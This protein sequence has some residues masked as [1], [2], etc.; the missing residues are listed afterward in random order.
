MKKNKNEL[1]GKIIA[2]ASAAGLLLAVCVLLAAAGKYFKEGKLPFPG[3]KKEEKGV[4]LREFCADGELDA[5]FD[6]IENNTP[7]ELDCVIYGEGPYDMVFDD[8]DFILR[9][10]R[11]LQTVRIGGVSNE[12]PDRTNDAG[13]TGYIFRMEDGTS[14]SFS[15]IL[16]SFRWKNGEYHVVES[17][18][19]LK[20]IS[21]ELQKAGN[22]QIVYAYSEDTGFYTEYL[23]TYREDWKDEKDHW[24][25]LFIYTEEDTDN[26][27]VE[28]SRYNG[29]ETDP[30]KYL[31]EEYMPSLRAQTEAEG[32]HVTEEEDVREYEIGNEKLPGLACILEDPGGNRRGFLALAFL[33]KDDLTRKDRL[34]RFCAA[35][36]PENETQKERIFRTLDTAFRYFGLSHMYY[37]KGQVQPD[38]ALA[39]FCNSDEL[40][41]WLDRT[42]EALPDAVVLMTDTWYM[43]ADRE[44]ILAVLQALQTVRIGQP[45]MKFS[46]AS[47]RRAY[48][49]TYMDTGASMT[50]TFYEDCFSWNDKTYQVLDWGQLKDLDSKIMKDK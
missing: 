18:G 24:G 25:G 1:P 22:P 44:T 42:K 36:D 12:N 32:G 13:G 27:F 16:G 28:I 30:E 49:F 41:E 15:F 48:S 14:V 45:S 10:V 21:S 5:W 40:N 7:V 50:F 20:K 8:R 9:T 3:T 11:A 23:E 38:N 29:S 33:T 35:W 19:D 39:D 47:G 2:I 26:Y 31:L 4:L 43:S 6:N 37:K 34:V 17:F 46:G